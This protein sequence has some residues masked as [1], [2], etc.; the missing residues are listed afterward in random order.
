MIPWV[1]LGE[2]VVPGEGGMMRLHQRGSEYSIRVGQYELMNSRAHSSEDALAAVVCK[3]VPGGAAYLVGGLGM[4]FTL[5][6]LLR[7]ARS[8]SKIVVSELVPE[9]VFWN[10]GAL[11]EVSGRPLDDPRVTVIEMD[12][13]EVIRQGKDSFDAILL[14][15]DNGPAALTSPG[16]ERLYSL[17]GLRTCRAALKPGGVLA[18]WSS[19][20]DPAFTQRLKKAGFDPRE[21]P[22][23]G[24]GA[25]GGFRYMIWLAHR[26][27][28]R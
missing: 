6:A 20:G 26:D 9:V 3:A 17:A 5:A 24:N 27:A 21:L 11:G 1:L 22:T 12:V 4:G 28:A 25:A 18:V 15:V 19:G 7:M 16:N 14:D 10:R 13:A 23:R 8:P 2:A